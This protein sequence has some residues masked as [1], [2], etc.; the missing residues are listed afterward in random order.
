MTTPK[1]NL[2]LVLGAAVLSLSAACATEEPKE[3][4]PSHDARL[5]GITHYL[6]FGDAAHYQIEVFTDEASAQVPTAAI[7]VSPEVLAIYFGDAQSDITVDP[8]GNLVVSELSDKASLT[9]LAQ[10]AGDSAVQ[11][12]LTHLPPP[13]FADALSSSSPWERVTSMGLDIVV[14]PLSA[15]HERQLE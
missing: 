9:L 3:V 14:P 11:D 12:A 7:D 8:L 15:T 6:V 2:G 4:E 10:V 5:E 1:M 13:A